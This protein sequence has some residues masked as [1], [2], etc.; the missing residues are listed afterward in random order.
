M[1]AVNFAANRQIL[2]VGTAS[3]AGSKLAEH[4]KRFNVG[5]RIELFVLDATV[6][7]GGIYRFT[8]MAYSTSKITWQGNVYEPL[9]CAADGFE[10][11]GSAQNPRPKIR[12]SNIGNVFSSAVIS[13]QDLR[14]S[15]LTRYRTFKRF[16]DGEPEADP[17]TYYVP[18]IFI[19][20][21]KST[22][23][24]EY[25]EWELSAP[26]DQENVKLPARLALKYVC[27]RRYRVWDPVSASFDYSKNQCPFD[28]S[29]NGGLM[30][31]SAD[32]PTVDP[33]QDICSRKDAGCLLRFPQPANNGLPTWAF[34]GIGN[35]SS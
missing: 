7:G 10:L 19:M 8:P 5:E 24:K 22:H 6:V 14:G 12:V 15:I 11:N 35:V 27:M 4:S 31:D 16:L 20:Q 18:D 30:F 33:A 29:Q 26:S 3:L 21:R 1:A 17:N 13:L 9:A 34:P 23:T 32:Q 28:G 2:L 25:I